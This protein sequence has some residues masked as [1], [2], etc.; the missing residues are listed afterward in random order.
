MRF[1]REVSE[2]ERHPE[3]VEYR[4]YITHL[5]ELGVHPY[6][7]PAF[8]TIK[9]WMSSQSMLWS[10]KDIADK[11]LPRYKE[12]HEKYDHE[13]PMHVFGLCSYTKENIDKH[14]HDRDTWIESQLRPE[15]EKFYLKEALFKGFELGQ[16][17]N[18]QFA[19]QS[20]QT[21]SSQDEDDYAIKYRAAMK[22]AQELADSGYYTLE[23]AIKIVFKNEK[24]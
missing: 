18:A 3:E 10:E 5:E 9:G 14:A 12:L 24:L 17:I 4:H 6:Y 19:Q 20:A 23:E 1:F 22:A 15:I 2:P 8:E 16:R 11:W 7:I 13:H 21:Q